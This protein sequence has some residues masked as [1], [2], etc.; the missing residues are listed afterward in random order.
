MATEALRIAKNLS[1]NPQKYVEK[2]K[3]EKFNVSST[4]LSKNDMR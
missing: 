1:T 3:E 4:S 2:Y